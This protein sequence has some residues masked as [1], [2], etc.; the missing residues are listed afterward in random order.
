M[1]DFIF[2]NCTKLVFGKEAET[3]VGKETVIYGRKVL[4]HYGGGS[5]KK[6]GLYDRVV[7][8]LHKEEI[9]VFELGGVKPNPRVDLVREGI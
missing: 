1:Q 4:L 8:S 5:I 6:S 7:E 3:S 9:E 2:Q